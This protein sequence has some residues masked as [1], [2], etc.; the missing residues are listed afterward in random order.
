MFAIYMCPFPPSR[1]LQCRY[2]HT[3]SRNRSRC[4]HRHNTITSSGDSVVAAAR[5]A[6]LECLFYATLLRNLYLLY[7]LIFVR[8]SWKL[9]ISHFTKKQTKS[10]MQHCSSHPYWELICTFFPIPWNHQWYIYTTAIG[11]CYITMKWM[12]W[13]SSSVFLQHVFHIWLTVTWICLLMAKDP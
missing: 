11:K 12:N 7:H 5:I 10:S 13:D 6:E 9:F 2:Y 1:Y 3:T 8:I 4:R